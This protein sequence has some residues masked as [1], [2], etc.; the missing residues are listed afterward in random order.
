MLTFHLPDGKE[1][2][3]EASVKEVGDT[4]AHTLGCSTDR[5]SFG[6][7]NLAL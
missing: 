2:T 1:E 5:P 3:P 7:A 4:G 6:V